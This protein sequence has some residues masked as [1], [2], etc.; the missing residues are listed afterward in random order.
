MTS[1]TVSHCPSLTVGFIVQNAD[2][3][4]SGQM[5]GW[6]CVSQQYTNLLATLTATVMNKVSVLN[7][8]R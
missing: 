1:H 6:V 3:A 2:T 5:L 7:K 4:E 8:Y